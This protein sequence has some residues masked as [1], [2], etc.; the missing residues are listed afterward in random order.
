MKRIELNFAPNS[1][2]HLRSPLLSESAWTRNDIDVGHLLMS[3]PKP[4][5][6]FDFSAGQ[7]EE[8]RLFFKHLHDRVVPRYNVDLYNATLVAVRT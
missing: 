4:P 3:L 2:E 1:R 5:L 7:R 8:Q 6:G